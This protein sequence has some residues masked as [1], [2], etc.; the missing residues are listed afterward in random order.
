MGY[1]GGRFDVLGD[2]MVHRFR[3]LFGN[4]KKRRSTMD[5]VHVNFADSI[6][7]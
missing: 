7:E 4:R 5:D 3:E 2:E 6:G 1:D